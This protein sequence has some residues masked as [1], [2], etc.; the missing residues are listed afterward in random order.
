MLNDCIISSRI[1]HWSRRFFGK[2]SK[3]SEF[4][5]SILPEN[6]HIGA[7]PY[8]SIIIVIGAQNPVRH[9]VRN[10]N[11]IETHVVFWII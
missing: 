4:G 10:S 11:T 3:F 7:T 9:C 5:I 6:T 2:F 8:D 1:I